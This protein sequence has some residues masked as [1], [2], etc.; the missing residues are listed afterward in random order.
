MN[1]R[2]RELRYILDTMLIPESR[3]EDYTWML[4]NLGIKNRLHLK[5]ERAIEL[6]VQILKERNAAV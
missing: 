3:M 4:R 6:I 5:Y 1:A 2:E